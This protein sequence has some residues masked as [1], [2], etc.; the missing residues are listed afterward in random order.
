MNQL[1][2]VVGNRVSE[3]ERDYNRYCCTN[4]LFESPPADFPA[5]VIHEVDDIFEH[6]ALRER[7]VRSSVTAGDRFVIATD[8]AWLS[9]IVSPSGSKF[10]DLLLALVGVV[11]TFCA[12]TM[13][14]QNKVEPQKELVS[15]AENSTNNAPNNLAG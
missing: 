10:A 11:E 12:A 7:D 15:I 2:I 8:L 1:P 5:D 6:E 9:I 13:N 3:V 14:P 4:E